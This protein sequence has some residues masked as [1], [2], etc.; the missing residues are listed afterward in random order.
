MNCAMSNITV[1]ARDGRVTT[2]EHA[3]IR[4]SKIRF[5]I[6]PDMLKVRKDFFSSAEYSIQEKLRILYMTIIQIN[7]KCFPIHRNELHELFCI[8]PDRSRFI[9]QGIYIFF[10]LI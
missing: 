7:F 9:S 5:L 10:L 1:T 4:G 6:L 3:Y 2:L 8:L